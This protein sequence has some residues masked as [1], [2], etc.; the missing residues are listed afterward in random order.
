[1]RGRAVWLVGL[2]PVMALGVAACSDDPPAPV[3]STDPVTSS[4]AAPTPSDG[5]SAPPE[6][7]PT[8][9]SGAATDEGPGSS[10][11]TGEAGE[12]G[13]TS[14][15]RRS[16]PAPAQRVSLVEVTADDDSVEVRTDGGAPGFD[17][18]YVDEV[19]I[20]GEPV[21]LDGAAVLQLEVTGADP[22]GDQGI[23]PEVGIDV[24][25]EGDGPV[26]R[27][28]YLRY[29]DGRVLFT[30]ELDEQLAYSVSPSDDGFTVTFAD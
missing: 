12:V 14:T 11:P 26:T 1:M 15:L 21:L 8:S 4:S 27:V 17:L 29:L 20:D 9:S 23:R 7:D 13:E 19:V 16:T 28:A 18:G 25:P 22:N 2:A 3:T 24:E 6:G 10:T 30:V 5:T